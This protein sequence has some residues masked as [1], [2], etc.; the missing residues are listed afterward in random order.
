[1]AL[2]RRLQIIVFHM[3][4]LGSSSRTKISKWNF[5]D[6][7]KKRTAEDDHGRRGEVHPWKQA[8]GTGQEK[9]LKNKNKKGVE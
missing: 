3:L 5:N 6:D 2:Q 1:M 9:K 8:Q 4:F 7:Q